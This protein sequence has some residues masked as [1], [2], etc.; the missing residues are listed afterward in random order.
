E[1]EV[2]NWAWDALVVAACA[3][4]RLDGAQGRSPEIDEPVDDA[5]EQSA[6]DDVADGDGQQVADQEVAP[7]QRG[8]VCRRRADPGPEFRGGERLD[9][10]AHRD[11]VHVRDAVLEASRDECR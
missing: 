2:S 8:E 1:E 5:D 6:A 4:S 7:R 9:A 3:R 10:Q 11:E